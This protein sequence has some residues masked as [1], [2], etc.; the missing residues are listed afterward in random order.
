MGNGRDAYREFHQR[1]HRTLLELLRAY[2]P[3]RRLRGLDVGGGGDIGGL[4][5]EVREQ[6]VEEWHAVDL[7]DDVERGQRQ[8]VQAVAC[9]I[10][11]EPLPYPDGNFDLV[12]FASVIEHL[13]NPHHAVREVARVLKPEGVLILEAP[14]AV[15]LGRRIDAVLGKNS[16]RWFNQYNALQDKAFMKFCAVFYTAEEIRALLSPYFM[17]LEQRYGMH[18]PPAGRVKRRLREIVF[19]LNPRLGD[20]FFIVAK[21]QPV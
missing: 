11:C 13:Y 6:L 2:V 7:G 15:A 4:A 18:D 19:R 3:Q 14:N 8:G 10:D 12:L 21:R 1:R 20:C 16:F 9:D 17:V 5:G